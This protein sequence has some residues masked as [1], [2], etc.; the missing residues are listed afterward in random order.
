MIKH[1]VLAF[2]VCLVTL[3]SSYGV[4]AYRTAKAAGP[5]GEHEAKLQSFRSRMISVPM[6]REDRVD[7]YIIAKFE[8]T[9]D[10]A[11]MKKATI[12]P[13]AFLADE[14]FKAIYN[15]SAKDLRRVP[16]HDLKQLTEGLVQRVNERVGSKIL[17]DVLIESW[18]FITMDD[19]MK[20][21]SNAGK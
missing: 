12:N 16:K 15:E 2:W 3:G 5:E 8:Y 6:T 14:A 18:V 21:N 13:A 9:A 4:M 20:I 1:I 19:M 11:A 10:A 7:G 17:H